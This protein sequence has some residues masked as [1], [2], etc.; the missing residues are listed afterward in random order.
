MFAII[1]D[2]FISYLLLVGILGDAHDVG[3]IP[4]H[5]SYISND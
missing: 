2:Q 3:K 4:Q 5:I 1:P